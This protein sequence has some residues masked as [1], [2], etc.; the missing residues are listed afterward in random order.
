VQLARWKCN[1]H[2]CRR[3]SDR[4]RAGKCHPRAGDDDSRSVFDEDSNRDTDRYCDC[5]DHGYTNGDLYTDTDRHANSNA[6]GHTNRDADRYAN[7]HTDSDTDIDHYG[8]PDAGTR[9]VGA[10]GNLWRRG[11]AGNGHAGH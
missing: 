3:F 7:S 1:E 4:G 8:D 9:S 5:Y 10:I 2:Y 6:D 11:T